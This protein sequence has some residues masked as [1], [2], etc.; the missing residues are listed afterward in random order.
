MLLTP[1]S[2]GNAIMFLDCLVVLFVWS[3]IVTAISRQWLEQF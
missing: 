1:D 3:N 2:I